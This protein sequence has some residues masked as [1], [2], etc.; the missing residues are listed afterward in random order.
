VATDGDSSRDNGDVTVVI[1]CFNYGRYLG[2]A[3]GSA[4]GQTGG[5]PHVIVVDDGSTE[6]ATL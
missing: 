4:L 3:A 1:S 5:A 6:P 2:E